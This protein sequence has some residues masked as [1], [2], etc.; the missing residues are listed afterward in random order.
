MP[1]PFGA[2]HE[3]VGFAS[4]DMVSVFAVQTTLRLTCADCRRHRLR[5]GNLDLQIAL[6]IRHVYDQLQPHILELISCQD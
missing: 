3:F 4:T 2:C 6:L 5:A 1:F